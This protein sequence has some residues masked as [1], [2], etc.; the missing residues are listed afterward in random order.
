MFAAVYP[1]VDKCAVVVALPSSVDTEVDVAVVVEDC[2]I[3]PKMKLVVE[4]AAL[5]DMTNSVNETML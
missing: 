1:W 3:P 5:V 4:I 2:D